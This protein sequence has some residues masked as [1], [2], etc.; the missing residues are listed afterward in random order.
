MTCTY[1]RQL[2]FGEVENSIA[3]YPGLSKTSHVKHLAIK[4]KCGLEQGQIPP[5]VTGL[6]NEVGTPRQL[7]FI[8]NHFR[9]SI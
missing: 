1:E 5:S 8:P 6:D 3:A 4:L 9:G 2:V 7:S